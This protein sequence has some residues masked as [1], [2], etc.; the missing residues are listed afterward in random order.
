MLDTKILRYHIE[1]VH[2]STPQNITVN[3]QSFT[4]PALPSSST[5]PPPTSS[6]PVWFTLLKPAQQSPS[7]T[8]T[9]PAGTTYRIGDSQNNKWSAPVTTT[10]TV[11]IVDYADGQ[12]DVLRIPI[13]LQSKNPQFITSFASI[14]FCVVS[15]AEV[16]DKRLSRFREPRRLRSLNFQAA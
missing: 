11:T 2:Q 12:N 13:R 10:T 15:T 1:T 9:L 7:T 6:T 4:A 14:L 16:P 5:Q 3:G 8:V